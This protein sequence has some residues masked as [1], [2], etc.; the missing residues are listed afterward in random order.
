MA[1]ILPAVVGFVL[2]LAGSIVTLV[3]QRKF[4]KSDEDAYNRKIVRSLIA[5]IEEA[6]SRAQHMAELAHKQQASYSRLYTALWQS[7]SQRLAATLDNA[8]VLVLLHRIY[9]RFDL[10][11]FMSEKGEYGRAG[12]FADM[13]L[14]GVQH[15][16]ASLKETVD[17]W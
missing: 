15:D 11:N 1:W 4:T 7:T 2:G 12:G 16:L 3:V 13:Y 5:E 6:V 9:Y 8:E 14:S 17:S 10:I